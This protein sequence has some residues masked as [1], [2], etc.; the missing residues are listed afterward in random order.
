MNLVFVE[1]ITIFLKENDV[2]LKGVKLKFRLI[3]SIVP[4]LLTSLIQIFT[5]NYDMLI[6]MLIAVLFLNFGF[7]KTLKYEKNLNIM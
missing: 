2:N 5:D 1:P 3:F 4:I 6:N 7:L